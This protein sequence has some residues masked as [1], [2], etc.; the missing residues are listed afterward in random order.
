[1]RFLLFA[2]FVLAPAYAAETILTARA[3]DYQAT[4]RIGRLEFRAEL[5]GT[6]DL[7]VDGTSAVAEVY[8]GSTMRGAAV[9]YTQPLPHAELRGFRA[10]AI[11][12]AKVRVL[13]QPQRSNGY[14]ARVRIESKETKLANVRLFWE[15]DGRFEGARLAVTPGEPDNAIEGRMELF[16]RFSNDVELRI[17]GNEVMADGPFVLHRLRFSQPMPKQ[18]LMKLSRQGKAEIVERP[19]GNNGY[20]ASVRIGKVK[21]E[22]EDRTIV[23]VWRR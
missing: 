1:L 16:G 12:A 7:T 18:A 5:A 23:L 21:P 2:A 17:R 22:G 10:L 4:S 6:I 19:D 8:T 14:K 9:V 11:G 3:T 20:T 15:K 13:E